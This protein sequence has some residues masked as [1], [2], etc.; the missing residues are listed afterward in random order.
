MLIT[1]KVLLAYIVQSTKN[2]G[3][4]NMKDK[5]YT[6]KGYELRNASKN[7]LTSSMEDYLE[8]IYRC[9][10]D[11]PYIRINVLAKLLNVRDSSVSKMVRKLGEAGYVNYKKYGI[12]TLTEKGERK[13][14]ILFDRHNIIADFLLL[15]GCEDDTLVQTELIEHNINSNTVFN[16]KVLYNFITQ[17]EDIF[18]RY[19]E[20]KDNNPY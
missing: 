8:M 4:D 10:L 20:F 16:F 7:T 14:K 12:V 9:S 6:V 11:E 5:F 2:T 19:I 17:N 13:G 3:G 1:N 18:D 15:I